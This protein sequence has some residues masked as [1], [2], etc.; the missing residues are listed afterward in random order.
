MASVHDNTPPS[1][2]GQNFK[3]AA[4]PNTKIQSSKS[5]EKVAQEGLHRI[6]EVQKA[7]NESTN[8][9]EFYIKMLMEKNGKSYEVAASEY[10]SMI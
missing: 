3:A 1:N 10:D 6:A 4:K 7:T 8:E 2:W 9:R 5:T